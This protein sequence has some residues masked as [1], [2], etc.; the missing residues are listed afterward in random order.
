VLPTA[1]CG[2]L[3]RRNDV[4][5]RLP[6]RVGVGGLD[7]GVGLTNIHN[8]Q[9]TTRER[10]ES[11][12]TKAFEEKSC[13]GNP[14]VRFDVGRV[15]P[16]AMPRGGSSRYKKLAAVG[17][18]AL[19]FCSTSYGNNN[20]SFWGVTLGEDIASTSSLC[21]STCTSDALNIE[22]TSV[23]I[24]RHFFGARWAKA[25]LNKKGVVMGVSLRGTFRR[26]MLRKESLA[27]LFEL[28]NEVSRH[29]GF[30]VGEYY[31]STQRPESDGVA[32]SDGGRALWTDMDTV[33]AYAT[34]TNADIEVSLRCSVN[35][36]VYY[37]PSTADSPVK[38]TV[39]VTKIS[40]WE[41]ERCSFYEAC[42]R[43]KGSNKH[44]G[45]SE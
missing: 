13:A 9:L 15:V 25:F 5:R 18:C 4:P 27:K 37:N 40:L 41:A 2:H 43:D 20:G 39:R 45:D 21:I 7:D 30:D 17:C 32:E 24:G 11:M 34:M 16:V 26:G 35:S 19:F 8:T 29:V 12:A 22:T 44:F 31:F 3:L 14:Y 33:Y 28:K 38:F 36:E 10:T 23:R 42:E 6:L 1:V